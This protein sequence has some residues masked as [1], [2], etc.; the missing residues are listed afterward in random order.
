MDS[1]DRVIWTNDC[2]DYEDWRSDL[3]EQ[4]PDLTDDER[5]RIMYEVNDSY[6]DDERLNLNIQLPESILII[7]DLGLWYGR[8][9]G[10]KTIESGNIRDCLTVGRDIE[11]ATWYVDKLGDL[12]CKVSHHDGT[13]YYL[14]R[15]WKSSATETQR[16]NLLEKILT[17][18]GFA[19]RNDIT[20]LTERLGDHIAKV[21]GWD[22]PWKKPTRS[23]EAR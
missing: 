6:L 4:Y 19:S 5:M 10:F 17:R 7:G 20:R 14:Y 1:T 11:Y 13:N 3:E 18:P 15:V 12:R 21:Y 16:E 22:T 23:N 9:Q 8:R 2:L